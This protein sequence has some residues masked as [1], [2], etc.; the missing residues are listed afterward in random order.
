VTAM[1]PTWTQAT[2]HTFDATAGSGSVITDGGLVIAFDTR[3][4][5]A[6]PLRTMRTGQRVRVAVD[7]EDAP[8]AI[9]AITL[10]T[11]PPVG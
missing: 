9:A 11:F 2:V 1:S 10:S 7:D 6:G 4:W 5:A 8:T 3:A